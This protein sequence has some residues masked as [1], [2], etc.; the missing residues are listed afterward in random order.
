MKLVLP[1]ALR[2][3]IVRRSRRATIVYEEDFSSAAVVKRTV[4]MLLL[5]RIP[6]M[7]VQIKRKKTVRITYR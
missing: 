6:G 1:N 5:P 4:A 3:N 2:F 7:V